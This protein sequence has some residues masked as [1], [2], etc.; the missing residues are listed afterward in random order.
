V[1]WVEYTFPPR[2]VDGE[3]C[4]SAAQ[5]VRSDRK[6]NWTAIEICKQVLLSQKERE[7]GVKERADDVAPGFSG[8]RCST[9]QTGD[10][11]QQTPE[12]LYRFG[13]F[14]ILLYGHFM[15]IRSESSSPR[16]ATTR[17][18]ARRG[19]AL[20]SAMGKR[21]TAN[22][23]RHRPIVETI[24]LLGCRPKNNQ[25]PSFLTRLS[26]ASVQTG[27]GSRRPQK[28]ARGR[29]V[30]ETHPLRLA[31][32]ACAF[33]VVAANMTRSRRTLIYIYTGSVVHLAYIRALFDVT[34][35]SVQ[36]DA[37]G[38]HRGS[39]E[40]NFVLFA[41]RKKHRD[42]RAHGSSIS[43]ACVCP[44]IVSRCVQIEIIILVIIIIVF[45]KKSAINDASH[46][47]IL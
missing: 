40:L 1:V 30:Q 7:R 45:R 9:T 5:N 8:C 42:V 23:R 3:K 37:R 33:V 11:R 20:R 12:T 47:Q 35:W 32:C 46:F 2:L 6:T 43:C 25:Q 15:P 27:N 31:I 34:W 17:S 29:G 18:P 38:A 24:L 28:S 13:S 19:C 39:C 36:T 16:R 21:R 10:R 14:R 41:D 44:S 26:F 22:R 4:W